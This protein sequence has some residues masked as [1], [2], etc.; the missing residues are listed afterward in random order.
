MFVT[1]HL[2]NYK[3]LLAID[4]LLVYDCCILNI[5][6][7]LV[8]QEPFSHPACRRG[9]FASVTTTFSRNRPLHD[10]D[11]DPTQVEIFL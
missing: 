4:K 11:W 10:S 9:A 6:S 7:S 3:I 8:R 5:S 2:V 1:P